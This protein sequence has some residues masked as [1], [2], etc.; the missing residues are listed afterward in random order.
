MTGN[1][2]RFDVN[3]GVVRCGPSCPRQNFFIEIN[4]KGFV[5]SKRSLLLLP[6]VHRKLKLQ[7]PNAGRK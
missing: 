3:T 5:Y 1:K 2:N 4:K 6:S 7:Q